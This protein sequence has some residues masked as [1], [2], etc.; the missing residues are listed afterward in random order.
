M[1]NP[2]LGQSE[3]KI[4]GNLWCRHLKAHRTFQAA[5]TVPVGWVTKASDD[6]Y[7]GGQGGERGWE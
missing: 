5:G 6:L 2:Y 3:S 1:R 7:R 4:R